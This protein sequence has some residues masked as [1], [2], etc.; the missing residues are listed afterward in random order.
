MEKIT[1]SSEKREEGKIVQTYDL[2]PCKVTDC[3]DAPLNY[4]IIYISVYNCNHFNLWRITNQHW[5]FQLLFKSIYFIGV[6]WNHW[7]AVF[8]R[9]SLQATLHQLLWHHDGLS[10]DEQAPLAS[11]IMACVF[12]LLNTKKPCNLNTYSNINRKEPYNLA[13][14]GCK[15]VCDCDTACA[16]CSVS[17]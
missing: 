12:N 9:C 11:W 7:N 4:F 15:S 14:Q 10:S 5:L 6:S 8:L 1:D 2:F 13:Q 17:G 3:G 16:S